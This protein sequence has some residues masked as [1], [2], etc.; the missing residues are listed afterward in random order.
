MER[1]VDPDARGTIGAA[2]ARTSVARDA[3]AAL[4]VAVVVAVLSAIALSPVPAGNDQ[5]LFVYYAERLR[6]GAML[7]TDVWDNKQPGIFGFY[8]LAG[9]LFGDGWPAA[10]AL[11]AAWL[12]AGAG[13]L[14]WTARLVAPGTVA[15]LIVPLATAG[16]T[17]LRTTVDHPAQVESLT[18]L[19]LAA[20]LLLSVARPSTR[21]GRTL[22]WLAAG[23][24]VG[25][26]AA[27]KL[28]LAPV[29][30]ALIACALGW[31]L[32]RGDLD[33]KAAAGAGALTLAGFALVWAPI[34]GW[35]VA[36]GAWPEFRWTM[37]EYPRL[38][39]AQVETRDLSSLRTALRWLAVG[40]APLVPVAAWYA[41]R[42]LRDARSP[43]ALVAAACCAWVVVGLAM[44]LTQRF[45]WWDTH[46]D[47]VLWPFGLL[48][49]LGAATLL[50]TARGRPH[51]AGA[52]TE[53]ARGSR[54]TAPH[55]GLA[56]AVVAV[57][58]LGLAAH[59]A[60]FVRAAAADPEWPGPALERDAIA[61]ARQV[62]ATAQAPCGTVYAIGDQAGVERATGLRQAIATHGLWFGAFLP[63]Q[64]DR[65]PGELK[66]ARPDLVYYDGMERLDFARKFPRAAAALDAWLASDYVP[67]REDAIGGRWWQRR[68]APDDAAS[69]PRAPRFTVPVASPA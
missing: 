53:S 48:A 35:I 55:R 39:L 29:P 62:G 57:M 1:V 49:A 14:A 8:A 47:L 42:S 46:M 31:L 54:G 65:L 61:L 58:A 59:G 27:L 28:V 64:A 33:P 41:L 13:L 63:A 17:V 50:R 38:A 15:W 9:A 23:A 18:G 43:A 51:A 36:H 68:V 6:A 19:P 52:R 24:L 44:F 60:R 30:A 25:V 2:P 16:L 40:V 20:L 5:A 26:V 21:A 22:A 3:A 56:I 12:G 66:A 34:V 10:R 11:Y 69:C 4:S 32:L 45:S 7:Y 37:L 67:L